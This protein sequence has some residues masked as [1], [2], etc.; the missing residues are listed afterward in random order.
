M[1]M[2]MFSTR[3]YDIQHFDPLFIPEQEIIQIKY[4]DTCLDIHT[5]QLA[6]GFDAICAFVN[7]DLSAPVLTELAQLGVKLVLMRCA[8]FNNVDLQASKQLGLTVMRVPAYSPEAIAEHA[9]ALA[10]TLNRRIHKAYQ[11]TRDANFSLEGLV[12]FNMFGKTVGVIGTGKIG[13][14]AMRILKGFGCKL[15]AYDPYPSQQAIELGAEYASLTELFTQSD[16]ITL[17]CPLTEENRH[18]LNQQS[19]AKMKD[20][21]MIINTSRGALINAKDS[22]EALKQ[23]KIGGLG[24]DVYEEEDSLFFN[25]HSSEIITDDVFR[26]LSSCHNVIFTGHQAFLTKEALTSIAQTTLDNLRSFA[27]GQSNGNTIG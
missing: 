16:L 6:N 25:D 10:M 2:A 24:L 17:H 11:R 3:S 9:I 19:F 20:G 18:L 4:F 27:S 26:R 23:G 5:C 22:I 8:G 13:I 14:A 1:K 12:G 7:D 15:L 21:V